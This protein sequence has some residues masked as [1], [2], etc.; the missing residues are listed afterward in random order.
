MAA[1]F[2]KQSYWHDRFAHESSF[3]WLVSS[4]TF[5]SLLEPYIALLPPSSRILHV[6][7]GTS[8]LH[9]HLRARGLLTVTNLDYEPLA[10]ERGRQLEV[11]HF[12]DARMDYVVADATQLRDP[13][14]AEAHHGRYDLIVDKSAADAVA[15]GGDDQ[16][17]A[18]AEGMGKC[19]APGGVWLSLSFSAQRF[20]V[21]GMPMD[22][23]L[24]DKIPT[25][26]ARPTDPDICYWFYAL[27]HW[28]GNDGPSST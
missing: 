5:L 14:Y 27:R 11:R 18:M 23:R 16:L 9:N 12:G 1:P 28:D 20:E 2:E 13:V 10:A 7:S 6:G 15:C 8:D 3:D 4:A 21:E 22:V 17:L 24:A 25:R 26:K 19:L